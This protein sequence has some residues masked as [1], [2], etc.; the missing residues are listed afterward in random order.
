MNN[1]ISIY[2]SLPAVAWPLHA[3]A[4]ARAAIEESPNPNSEG[5]PRNV[6]A[7]RGRENDAWD[8]TCVWTCTPGPDV[9]CGPHGFELL[10]AVGVFGYCSPCLMLP[11]EEGRVP[12]PAD[13]GRGR[14]PLPPQAPVAPPVLLLPVADDPCLLP[15]ALLVTQE[16]KI[17][18]LQSPKHQCWLVVTSQPIPNLHYPCIGGQSHVNNIQ[19]CHSW[20]RIH[21]STRTFLHHGKSHTRNN[22]SKGFS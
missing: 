2:T 8:C 20:G 7:L 6:S 4:G 21:K 5:P 9:G 11:A 1:I 3:G 18:V 13:A 17:L 15:H 22:A 14:L 16:E 10:L 19:V 12:L